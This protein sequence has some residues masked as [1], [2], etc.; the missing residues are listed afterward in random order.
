MMPGSAGLG[1]LT[2][3][4]A[5]VGLACSGGSSAYAYDDCL[6]LFNPGYEQMAKDF[7]D[8][9]FKVMDIDGDRQIAGADCSDEH[10][11]RLKRDIRGN[12][13]PEALQGDE[14]NGTTFIAYI[15]K[16]ICP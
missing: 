6:K 7:C 2:A 9:L 11:S 15:D 14:L 8:G 4:L 1:V 13:V 16:Y 5:A 12:N 3:T 10:V